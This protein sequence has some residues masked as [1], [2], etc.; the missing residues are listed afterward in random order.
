MRVFFP[1]LP[2]S[3]WERNPATLRVDASP[4]RRDHQPH[5]R[6][7]Q[8]KKTPAAKTTSTTDAGS[9]TALTTPPL[10]ETIDSPNSSPHKPVSL[11]DDSIAG[12]IRCQFGRGAERISPHHKVGRVDRA[13]SVVIP[14]LKRRQIGDKDAVG[15]KSVKIAQTTSWF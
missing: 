6:R 2:H 10:P 14:R 8:T 9:G 4:A 1:S 11:V 15:V 13:I 3:A 7:R 12:A 5:P